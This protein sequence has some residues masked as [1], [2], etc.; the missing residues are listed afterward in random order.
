M[1]EKSLI[2]NTKIV[3]GMFN[4]SDHNVVTMEMRKCE[5]QWLV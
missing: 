1:K 2:E 3:K 5:R 4:G